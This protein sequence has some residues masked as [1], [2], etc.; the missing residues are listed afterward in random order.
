MNEHARTYGY[1]STTETTRA[2][3]YFLRAKA[4]AKRWDVSLTTL[5]RQQQRG[6]LPPPTRLSPGAKG[7]RI[8]VIEALEAQRSAPRNQE[9]VK[10]ANAE[11]I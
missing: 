2:A 1:V 11:R 3:V 8:D 9:A 10:T 5:W 7:W 4:L 6:D